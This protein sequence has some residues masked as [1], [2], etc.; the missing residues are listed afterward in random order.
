MRDHAFPRLISLQ[1]VE[2]AIKP[3]STGPPLQNPVDTPSAGRP[4]AQVYCGYRTTTAL[5]GP[6]PHG[7][8]SFTTNLHLKR[9]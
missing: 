7:N 5:P 3:V 4:S 9:T 8:L 6:A 2:L 1:R